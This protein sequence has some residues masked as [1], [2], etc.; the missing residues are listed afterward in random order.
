MNCKV[1][2]CMENAILMASGM[3]TRMRPLTETTPK[4]LIRVGNK[5]MIET[6]IDGLQKRGVD[7]IVVVVGYLGEQFDY[8]K[9]KYHNITIVHN[10]VYE[11]I[12]NISSV[13][14]AKETLLQ[15]NC[16]ICEADLYVSDDSIFL[17]ELSQSCY[18]GKMV[19]GH[20][21]DWVFD[22]NDKGIITR[23]GKVG[24]D[25]YNMT[26]VAYFKEDDA[27]VLYDII[28]AEYGISGYENMFWDDVV[29]KHI[30]EFS[31]MVHPVEHS[32][33]VEIDTVEELE[34]VCRRL[35]KL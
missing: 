22:Q 8:L 19:K 5:P 12:N 16:F 2:G 11:K 10:T 13:F 14:A 32:Q 20:S 24:D 27:R 15:G 6:V 25:C 23:V 18:Y 33:I 21:E 1:G 31:L 30:K 7:R 4:P 26:G 28:N 29:N 3:G 35:E 17:P 34:E 9:E